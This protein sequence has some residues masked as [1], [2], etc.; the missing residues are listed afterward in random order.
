MG[1]L[2][3]RSVVKREELVANPYTA[4]VFLELEEDL[5]T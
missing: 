3:G 4:K 1:G 2:G 5:E